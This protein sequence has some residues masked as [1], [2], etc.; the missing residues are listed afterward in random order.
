[1]EA[2]NSSQASVLGDCVDVS[3]F[4][5]STLPFLTFTETLQRMPEQ[6]PGSHQP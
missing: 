2:L 3:N 4:G 1:L 6:H 5:T